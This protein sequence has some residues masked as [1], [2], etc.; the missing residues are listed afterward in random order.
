MKGVFLDKN[1][2]DMGDIDFSYLESILAEW[3]FYEASTSEQ[4]KDRVRDAEVVLTN[5]VVLDHAI[6][7]DADNLELICVTAT[8]TNNVDLEAA[9]A[10][11]IAVC[12]VRA[13][14]TPS[15]VQHVFALILSL[16]RKLDSHHT[17]AM[18]GSWSKSDQFCLLDYPIRELAGL[19]LGIVGYGELGKAVAK[20]AGAFDMDVL[21]AQRPGSTGTTEGRMPLNELLSQV[22]ILSLHCPLTEDTRNLIGADELALMKQDALLINAAR[23]AL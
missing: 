2:L 4:I 1:S 9:R 12:N 16:T 3:Q 6:I 22:D 5:K 21:I 19:K 15:V 8:G 14:A 17:A 7:N 13:Y 11:N 10:K 20:M 18:D 23:V